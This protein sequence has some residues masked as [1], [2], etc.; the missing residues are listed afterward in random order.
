MA[1]IPTVVLIHHERQAVDR[2]LKARNLG[3]A[4]RMSLRLHRVVAASCPNGQTRWISHG[5]ISSF[6]S[7]LT[8]SCSEEAV[9]ILSHSNASCFFLEKGCYYPVALGL[10]PFVYCWREILVNS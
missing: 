6:V 8:E 10:F 3:D 7:N 4:F 2:I 9:P 5:C 1:L